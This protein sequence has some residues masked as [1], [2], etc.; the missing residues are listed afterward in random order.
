MMPDTDA[1]LLLTDYSNPLVGILTLNRPEKRNALSIALTEQLADAV[2]KSSDGP[3]RA[4]V[5]RANGPIFC[6]GLDLREAQDE[7]NSERSARALARLYLAIAS[8]PLITIASARGG[9]FGGGVGILA[10][11]DL[12]I[13]ADDLR[14][15]FPEVHRGLVAGLVT[16]ILRRQTNGNALREAILLG[17]T[18]DAVEAQKMGIIQR[19]CAECELKSATMK[20]AEIACEGAPGAIARTKRLLDDLAARPLSEDIDRAL[21]DHLTARNSAEAR[22]GVNAFLQHRKPIWSSCSTSSPGTP[23]ED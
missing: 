16:A 5:L 3:L 13:A 11:C 10:A 1:P 20:L 15:G 2:T 14:I 21:Q 9:A 17:Q 18:L 8:S 7:A 6:A 22:E 19:I 12:C 4:L 23:G